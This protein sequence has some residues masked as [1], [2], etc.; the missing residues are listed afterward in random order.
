MVAQEAQQ[1]SQSGPR[2][3]SPEMQKLL[4]TFLGTWLVTEELEA[5]ET[6]PNGAAGQGEEVYRLGPGGASII[7]EIHLKEPGGD[8]SGLGVGWWDQQV[9]GVQG[10]LVR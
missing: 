6:M 5:N 8:T 4:N 7:E 10:C 1:K 3:P 9:P 2:Q